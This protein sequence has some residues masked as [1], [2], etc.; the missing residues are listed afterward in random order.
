VQAGYLRNPIELQLA[1][2]IQLSLLPLLLPLPQL[3]LM[4]AA[5]AAFLQI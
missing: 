4:L 5:V 3:L 2:S 1:S